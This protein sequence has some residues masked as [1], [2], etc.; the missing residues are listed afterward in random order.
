MHAA[1]NPIAF[2]RFKKIE[3]LSC[4]KVILMLHLYVEASYL[5]RPVE[6]RGS[7]HRHKKSVVSCSGQILLN[8]FPMTRDTETRIFFRTK[9]KGD[10]LTVLVGYFFRTKG[11]RCSQ[12]PVTTVTYKIKWL[13]LDKIW[14]YV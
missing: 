3:H 7:R 5:P 4:R 1:T 13:N 10:G 2:Q 11:S 8:N 14:Q 9:G 6:L 12:V